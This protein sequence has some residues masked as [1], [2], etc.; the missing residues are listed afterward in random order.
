[1]GMEGCSRSVSDAAWSTSESRAITNPLGR[2]Y[3]SEMP[4]RP[5][6]ALDT[7]AADWLAEALP[8]DYNFVVGDWIPIHLD[9]IV[10]IGDLG[11]GEDLTRRELAPLIEVLGRHTQA[12][13]SC[14][15]CVWDGYGWI[16]GSVEILLLDA[17]PDPGPIEPSSGLPPDALT[18]P[19][20]QRPSREYLLFAGPLESALELGWRRDEVLERE[21]PDLDLVSGE[22]R[23]QI[24]DLMWPEDRAWFFATDTDFDWS[25][26]GGSEE[27]I[28]DLGVSMPE[29]TQV[30]RGDRVD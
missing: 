6:L 27:L 29:V 18:R 9:S 19:R 24:A 22:H 8:R 14:C 15:F 2:T 5:E 23:P 28:A 21:Y 16:N 25:Y 12:S 20:V 13:E 4:R 3:G 30:Q 7:T 1:M 17:D 26:I 11:G 10:R